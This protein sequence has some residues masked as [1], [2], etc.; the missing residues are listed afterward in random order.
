MAVTENYHH[1]VLDQ[2][3]RLKPVTSRKMFGGI[4]VYH[5]GIMF[6][7]IFDDAVYFRVDDTNRH[8][9]EHAGYLQL[10]AHPDRPNHRMPY[11]QIPDDLLDDPDRLEP[12]FND[13]LEAARR[14][15]SNNNRRS[16]G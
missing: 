14:A 3:E 1:Y 8:N 5:A 15:K 12:W 2:L 10:P 11:F 16:R 7:L 9:Y 13:T 6:A 4:G